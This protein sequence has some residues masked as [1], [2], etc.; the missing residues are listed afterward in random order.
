MLYSNRAT[1]YVSV[2]QTKKGDKQLSIRLDSED[3]KSITELAKGG[4][5]VWINIFPDSKPRTNKN[6]K[7]YLNAIVNTTEARQTATA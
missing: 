5:N 1:Q 3:I 7:P 6:G 2:R 4:K